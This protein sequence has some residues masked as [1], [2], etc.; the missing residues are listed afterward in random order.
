MKIPIATSEEQSQI[1]DEAFYFRSLRDQLI[2]AYDRKL[3]ALAELK[4]SILHQAFTGQLTNTPTEGL[5][6]A[7]L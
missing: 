6:V 5:K 1:V 2:S 4:Q 3:D 7:G